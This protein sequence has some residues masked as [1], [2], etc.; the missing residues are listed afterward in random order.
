MFLCGNLVQTFAE[1]PPQVG[2]IADIS[3]MQHAGLSS[4]T[5]YP[6][7]NRHSILVLDQHKKVI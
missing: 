3:S 4:T 5:Q 6:M 2:F 7:I 1:R